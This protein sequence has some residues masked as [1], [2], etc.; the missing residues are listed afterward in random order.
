MGY[1]CNVLYPEMIL[2][3]MA[4]NELVK[5]RMSRLAKSRYSFEALLTEMPG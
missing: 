1:S 5:H 3:M 4:L 2:V